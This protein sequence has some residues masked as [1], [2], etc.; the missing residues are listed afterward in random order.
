MAV[1]ISTL[2]EMAFEKPEEKVVLA[3]TANLTRFRQ[4]FSAQIRREIALIARIVKDAG[5]RGD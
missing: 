2:I 1:I 5:I 4:D 3:G